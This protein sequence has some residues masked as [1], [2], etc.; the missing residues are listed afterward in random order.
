MKQKTQNEIGVEGFLLLLNGTLISIPFNII[1]AGLLSLDFFY[2]HVPNNIVFS[3]FGAIFFLTLFR[4][5][6]NQI[7]IAKKY[8]QEHFELTRF[9]F[10]VFIF[11]NGLTWGAAFFIF[12]PIINSAQQT[13]LALVLGGM[14]AGGIAALAIYLAAFYAYVLPMFVPIIIYDFYSL[15]PD[16]VITGVLYSMFLILICMTARVNSR[17]L[18][19]T[20]KLD[21]EKDILI[22]ELKV[23][24]L[25]LEK[26]IGEARA[27][28]ITDSLTGLYN[29]RYFDMIFYNELK[30]AQ[31]NQYAI[32]LVLIDIDNFKYI[33]DTFGHP[34]GDDFLVYVASSLKKSAKRANDI[35][36][37][38]GGDEFALILSNMLLT[39][40]MY[41][42]GALQNRFDNNNQHKNVTLSMGVIC[43]SSFQSL[44]LQTVIT[45]A[46]RTLYQAKKD[47]KNK[48]IAKVIN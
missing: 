22:K 3:W 46:D 8:Y 31:R 44:D 12:L 28:S 30:K 43:I 37:R 36:F 5:I 38:L 13:I 7:I 16:M 35:I 18:H 40:V 11:L 45:A 25:K 19:A 6:F 15:N 34:S 26:S 23:S 2:H 9:L 1:G 14:S 21:R 47:G 32:N 4:L 41:F 10:L 42:C 33:N 39:D 17:L 24:N 27:M 48:I 20:F 29:R